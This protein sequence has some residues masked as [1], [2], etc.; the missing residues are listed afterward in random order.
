M[1]IEFSIGNYRSFK[2]IQTLSLQAAKIKSKIKALDKDNIFTVTEKLSLLKSKAIYGANASGK[3]NIILAIQIFQYLSTKS[4]TDQKIVELIWDQ[5]FRLSAQSDNSPIF[6][7]L[8]FRNEKTIY[9]YGFEILEREVIAEWLYGIPNEKE[10]YFFEREGE[11]L[12]INENRFKEGKRVQLRAE[13]NITLFRKTSLFLGVVAAFNG[14]LSKK[15]ISQIESIKI[16]PGS[17]STSRLIDSLKQEFENKAQ[18]SKFSKILNTL[19]SNIEAIEIISPSD[20]RFKDENLSLDTKQF[21]DKKLINLQESMIV[22]RKRYDDQNKE[23]GLAPFFLDTEEAEG[24]K[25]LV[26]FSPFLL[27]SM[28]TGTPL[29]IDEFD[30]HLHPNLTR[31]IVE[32]F[33]N[34]ISNPNNAQLIFATHDSNLLDPHLLRRDQ[35]CFVEKDKFGASSLTNL[36]EFKGIRNDAS[37]EKD[38]LRGK[39]GAVPY[40]G[41]FERIFEKIDE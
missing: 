9:R 24:N 1:F 7:Q 17:I 28:E 13:K 33:Q 37:Y 40:L 32:L 15:L 18:L 39:Y 6:F 12:K 26:S 20:I 4:L 29:I 23:I 10:V 41:K 14:S 35:I 38:Y 2:E 19:D 22:L 16:I 21:L 31:K 3:S 27:E 36:I 30:A 25:R 5:R 8:V 11:K 34:P